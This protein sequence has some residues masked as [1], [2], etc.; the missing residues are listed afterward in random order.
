MCSN[1]VYRADGFKVG[2]DWTR[3]V[4]NLEYDHV[5]VGSSDG[6]VFIWDVSNT[7]RPVVVLRNEHT[8]DFFLTKKC[9]IIIIQNNNNYVRKWFQ[10]TCDGGVLASVHQ[11]R[12]Q[13]GQIQEDGDLGRRLT[14]SYDPRLFPCGGR[15]EFSLFLF[16]TIYIYIYITV[17][18]AFQ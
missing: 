3:A 13:R 1:Y 18:I 11:Q 15:R 2:C 16:I 9:L 7:E 12:G 4:F 17:Y 8:W 5:A 14:S 6:S 10:Y